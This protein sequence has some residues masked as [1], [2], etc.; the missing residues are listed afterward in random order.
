M[1]PMNE[2]TTAYKKNLNNV[3]LDFGISCLEKCDELLEVESNGC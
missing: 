2:L 1:T 3:Y